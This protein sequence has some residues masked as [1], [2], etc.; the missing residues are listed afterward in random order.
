MSLK[1]YD[2]WWW[3][4]IDR[5][6][7][8]VILQDVDTDVPNLLAHI[9]GR[10]IIVQAGANVGVYP[11]ALAAHFEFVVTVEP[12]EENYACLV[13]NIG[14]IPN[15]RYRRAAF[16]E[17]SGRASIHVV[18]ADNVGAHRIEPGEGEIPVITIDD[19]E[20]VGCD[21]IWLDIEGYELPALKGAART[22]EQFSPVICV[23]DKGLNAAF[24]IGPGALQAWLAERGYEQVGRF[25]RDKVF[26]R[27]K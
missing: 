7:R 9:P 22:I 6:A 12:D 19:M 8:G 20:L 23:E 26:R 3:P 15:I 21:A 2:G 13:A 4:E 24:G 18:R 1:L 25:G 17:A 16:G 10:Q 11:A 27:T 5:S 14:R